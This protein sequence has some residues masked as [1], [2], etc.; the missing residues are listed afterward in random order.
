MHALA[1]LLA[2]VIALPAAAHIDFPVTLT[3]E[4]ETD[5]VSLPGGEN[6]SGTA[7]LTLD[8]DNSLEYQITITGPLTGAPVAAH[9]HKGAIGVAGGVELVLD[10]IALAG[11]TAPLTNAQLIALFAGDLYVN[12]HTAENPNGEVRGQLTAPAPEC[13][14]DTLST[15]DFKK[16]VKERLK[17]LEQNERKSE[18][19]KALKKAAKKASCGKT[20][21]PKK[22]V[23]CC[24]PLTPFENIV[25]DGLC[26]AI[27]AKKCAKI[28]GARQATSCF[29]TNPCSPSGAF[30][31]GA[32]E[33]F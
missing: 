18:P 23:G 7:T 33:I 4:Q 3:D 1:L 8:N 32:A 22:A 12:V 24:V 16:C 31:D 19:A 17:G 21:G 20:K 14:C 6:P 25:T 15:K 28:E 2:L 10:H 27:S 13:D 30:L 29:P 5:P 26:H 9:I 11:T